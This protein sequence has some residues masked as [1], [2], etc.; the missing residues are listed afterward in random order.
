MGNSILKNKSL[1]S[2]FLLFTTFALPIFLA[3]C[4][5]TLVSSPE[6]T[7]TSFVEDSGVLVYAPRTARAQKVVFDTP[8]KQMI[9]EPDTLFRKFFNSRK[10]DFKSGKINYAKTAIIGDIVSRLQ[11]K[12]FIRLMVQEV[13]N[14]HKTTAIAPHSIDTVKKVD[15]EVRSLK[16]AQASL[17]AAMASGDLKRVNEKVSLIKNLIEN[18]VQRLDHLNADTRIREHMDG[19]SFKYVSVKIL[20]DKLK[21]YS[22]KNIQEIIKDDSNFFANKFKEIKTVIDTLKKDLPLI[23]E[24]NL[25]D[26][27][28]DFKNKFIN[29]Q[30]GLKG[31]TTELDEDRFKTEFDLK[32]DSFKATVLTSEIED[33]INSA[34][35]LQGDQNWPSTNPNFCAEKLGKKEEASAEEG[36]KTEGANIK[37]A[38]AKADFKKWSYILNKQLDISGKPKYEILIKINAIEVQVSAIYGK[39]NEALSPLGSE[40]KLVFES[41]KDKASINS[42]ILEAKSK[43]A[44]LL[45]NSLFKALMDENYPDIRDQEIQNRVLEK[46]TMD[47]GDDPI[48]QQYRNIWKT[49]TLQNSNGL[50]S[51]LLDLFQSLRERRYFMNVINEAVDKRQNLFNVS[52]SLGGSP[53][54]PLAEAKRQFSIFANNLES[55]YLPAVNNNKISLWQ[56]FLDEQQETKPASS[57]KDAKAALFVSNV[58]G[59]PLSGSALKNFGEKLRKS[60]ATQRREGKELEPSFEHALL[61]HNDYLLKNEAQQTNDWKEHL[62]NHPDI[63]A[64]HRSLSDQYAAFYKIKNSFAL[65][66][67]PEKT[68]S[69]AKQAYEGELDKVDQYM[70]ITKGHVKVLNDVVGNLDNLKSLV[71]IESSSGRE[72][73][74]INPKLVTFLKKLNEE[75]K[76]LYKKKLPLK[77]WSDSSWIRVQ[78]AAVLLN[79]TLKDLKAD[80]EQLLD[81]DKPDS[82]IKALEFFEELKNA[83]DRLEQDPKQNANN[84]VIFP[85]KLKSFV[86][87][88][89][90]YS[91]VDQVQA[92]AGKTLELIDKVKNPYTDSAGIAVNPG[93]D[94][95]IEPILTNIK[96]VFTDATTNDLYTLA[97]K[98]KDKLDAAFDYFKTDNNFKPVFQGLPSRYADYLKRQKIFAEEKPKLD[99]AKKAYSDARSDKDKSLAAVTKRVLEK[100]NNTRPEDQKLSQAG[101]EQ[102]TNKFIKILNDKLDGLNPEKTASLTALPALLDGSLTELGKKQGTS[103]TRKVA[104]ENF[105]NL[106]KSIPEF[107]DA[108]DPPIAALLKSTKISFPNASF[109]DKAVKSIPPLFTSDFLNAAGSEAPESIKSFEVALNSPSVSYLFGTVSNVRAVIE[110]FKIELYNAFKHRLTEAL[111]AEREANYDYWWLTFY[112]KAI[113][114]GKKS[115]EGQSII[116]IG[117]SEDITPE[118]QYH[119]WL[120]D[121]PLGHREVNSSKGD[122]KNSHLLATAVVKDFLT[123]LDSTELSQRFPHLRGDLIQAL[124]KFTE[125]G[126]IEKPDTTHKNNYK[127]TFGSEDDHYLTNASVPANEISY[128]GESNYLTMKKKFRDGIKYLYGKSVFVEKNR[129]VGLLGRSGKKNS[130]KNKDIKGLIELVKNSISSLPQQQKELKK[131][132]E[133]LVNA[134]FPAQKEYLDNFLKENLSNDKI[135]GEYG[136]K[137]YLDVKEKLKGINSL[138]RDMSF[139]PQKSYVKE[140]AKAWKS[141]L[142]DL[143]VELNGW[144]QEGNSNDKSKIVNAL[145]YAKKL[146]DNFNVLN[147]KLEEF[148]KQLGLSIKATSS[149]DIDSSNEGYYQRIQYFQK[150]LNDTSQGK[151]EDSQSCPPSDLSVSL[152]EEKESNKVCSP[153]CPDLNGLGQQEN[154]EEF[155]SPI[156]CFLVGLGKVINK[157]D[158]EG[159]SASKGCKEEEKKKDGEASITCK[160]EGNGKSEKEN[161]FEFIENQLDVYRLAFAWEPFDIRHVLFTSLTA[162]ITQS[163]L[164][165]KVELFINAYFDGIRRYTPDPSARER[166]FLP[167]YFKGQFASDLAYKK[168]LIPFRNNKELADLFRYLFLK[169]IEEKS[170]A[171]LANRFLFLTG[172]KRAGPLYKLL[173]TLKES[174]RICTEFA[175][176]KGTS[177]CTDFSTWAS[178]KFYSEDERNIILEAKKITKNL[179]VK[180]AYVEFNKLPLTHVEVL[181]RFLF[182]GIRYQKQAN[183]S[184]YLQFPPLLNWEY[185]LDV[186]KQN[187]RML[188][189]NQFHTKYP[190]VPDPEV[191]KGIFLSEHKNLEALI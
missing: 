94:E 8:D 120:Q 9:H 174:D 97:H 122:A 46:F 134:K 88:S 183:P 179:S 159:I 10:E 15:L 165:Q 53:A 175:N 5:P 145:D 18:L 82:V 137:K 121:R 158:K 190:G 74:P 157:W 153:P 156:T 125:G 6:G 77:K 92:L 24:W 128:V 171:N 1:L 123:I 30:E 184:R 178:N 143:M 76:A 85:E 99:K 78:T 63:L 163:A 84:L 132:L 181:T 138:L 34:A 59:N 119:R 61:K 32:K 129:L 144:T 141:S 155:S 152:E 16:K 95:K 139:N 154:D 56:S 79:H 14:R 12:E 91:Y 185:K 102:E 191:I 64:A 136:D 108:N 83:E 188:I 172:Q 39:L 51:L 50:N 66:G 186:A 93:S 112:P 36:A 162:S 2:I 37:C 187:L 49:T 164:P 13:V 167:Q 127:P 31:V 87:N 118:E 105:M 86:K 109:R 35:S 58:N 104:L 151:F 106:F 176:S 20:S 4:A 75:A 17:K 149:R 168:Y 115:V 98:D 182:R 117:F 41:I 107:I 101:L 3:G 148:D 89:S 28:A 124:N 11:N 177:S 62:E 19:G 33:L 160:K 116:E 73:D 7:T 69:A 47:P 25:G 133:N 48:H 70:E 170:L 57:G 80:K 23:Q 110:P 71:E 161:E 142:S 43:N 150:A 44:E 38:Y 189:S 173:S 90:D 55:E 42:E 126:R 45:A 114:L 40:D 103:N 140:S 169:G 81:S 147:E 67:G 113:P 26:V 96:E 130:R 54:G 135:I 60:F 111:K 22:A 65:P 72:W 29:F 146:A 21:A 68:L 27:N 100:F 166:L 52:G 131:S 180:K